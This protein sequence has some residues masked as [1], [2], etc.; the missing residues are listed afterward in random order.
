M[1]AQ[2]GVVRCKEKSLKDGLM[3]GGTMVSRIDIGWV[4]KMVMTFGCRMTLWLRQ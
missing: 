2:V 4:L 3:F 1:E